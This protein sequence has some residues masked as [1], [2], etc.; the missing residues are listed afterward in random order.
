MEEVKV[1]IVGQSPY[2]NDK[3]YG[4]LKVDGYISEVV[5]FFPK[6]NDEKYNLYK[7]TTYRRLLGFLKTKALTKE[8]FTALDCPKK[9]V[10][11]Y[12]SQGIYFVNVVDIE[13]I[14]SDTITFK[15]TKCSIYK[16]YQN[17]LFWKYSD[18]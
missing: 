4:P 14:D 15:S 17:Y 7:L 13:S 3:N 5:A 18:K 9:L 1:L 11:D 12:K 6:I 2:E 8:E 10:N 16:K